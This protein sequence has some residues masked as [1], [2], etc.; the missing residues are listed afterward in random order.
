MAATGDQ[1]EHVWGTQR[2]RGGEQRERELE[3]SEGELE[4][5]EG[6]SESSECEASSNVQSD[7]DSDL[8]NVTLHELQRRLQDSKQYIMYTYYQW[9]SGRLGARL[10][11]LPPVLSARV[12]YH[13]QL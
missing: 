6:E 2:E 12:V 11:P 10:P 8:D 7:S 9:D 5:S 4:S 13:T 1:Q 3:S